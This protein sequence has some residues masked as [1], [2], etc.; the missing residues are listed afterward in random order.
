MGHQIKCPI[1]SLVVQFG[2]IGTGEYGVNG[3][4]SKD[5]ASCTVT[6][7]YTHTHIDTVYSAN[8]VH[9][10]SQVYDHSEFFR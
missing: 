3:Q 7:T 5:Q 1:K 9:R 6:H 4:R 10:A 2:L 8:N